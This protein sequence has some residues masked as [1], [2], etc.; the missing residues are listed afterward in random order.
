MKTTAAGARPP[1][2]VLSVE[3]EPDFSEL[4]RRTLEREG[5]AVTIERAQSESELQRA[6]DSTPWDVVISDHSMPHFSSHDAL[7]VISA[8]GL[9]LPFI[10]VSG[11]IGE[12][13]AVAAMRAGAHDYV[14]KTNLGR[15]GVAVRRVLQDAAE[16]AALR[17][18]ER[19][20]EALHAVAFATGKA[21]DIDRLTEFAIERARTHLHC[22]YV[23]LYWWS[24]E[25]GHLERIAHLANVPDPGLDSVLPGSGVSGTAFVEREAVVVDDYVAWAGR[26]EGALTMLASAAATPMIIGDRVAGVITIGELTPR[27]FA[28]EEM[29]F[30]S[31]FAAEVA[32]AIETSRLLAAAQ[33][34]ARYDALTGL[35]NRVLFRERLD[36]QIAL[37]VR[38]HKTFALMYADLDEFREINDALGHEAGD[39]VL[40]ELGVRLRQF[41]GIGDSVGRFGADEFAVLFP[42]GTGIAQARS[43]A[44]QAVDFLKEP[45]LAAGQS[46]HLAA[47]I[48]IVVFPE[49]GAEPEVL[50]QRA[51]SAMFAAKRSQS[52]YRIYSAELDPQSQKRIALAA[53][54][55]RAIAEDELVL[56][57]QPQIDCASGAVVA[58]EALLRWNQP[59]RGLVPPMEFIP[60][61]EQSGLILEI[62][63]WV[64]REALR[65]AR[66]WRAVGIDLRVSV[67]VAMRNLLD[68]TFP[69]QVERL[70]ANSGVPPAALT[71]EITEGTIM[72]EPE[73]TL[74]LLQ[75]FRQIGLGVAIDDFGTGYSSLTYLSRLQVDEVKIDK[76]FVMA[77]SDRGNRAIVDAVVQL[78]RA[79]GLRVVAEGVKDQRTWDTIAGYPGV[80]AQGFHMSPPLPADQFTRWMGTRTA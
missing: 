75:R 39:S 80:V 68:P 73:R 71:L 57:Y 54:L 31:V 15:L 13:A 48:G 24:A 30:L 23:A 74:E 32:P 53:D 20:L 10:I 6:L 40:R 29:R 76:S 4:I 19:D 36:A 69:S 64:V 8:R 3:D 66:E 1:L 49:H 58:A 46:V 17:Q 21:L 22:D 42:V 2:R 37:S 14:P 45:F 47:S 60:F 35:P 70:V 26:L 61:A 43:A 34:A 59:G 52:R 72:L 78:G 12:E 65:Q 51:E 16:R 56:F 9:D 18:R 41:V 77:L 7:R 33:H 63:P 50:L 27:H 28:P 38:E 62:T 55:R 44:E 67:N 79:F 25:R 11:Y 5:F